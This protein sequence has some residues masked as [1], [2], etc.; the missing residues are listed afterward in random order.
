MNTIS[1][2]TW[3]VIALVA[4]AG[5]AAVG[6]WMVIERRRTQ[7]LRAQFGPEYER[8]LQRTRDRRRVEGK[9][10]NRMK[11]VEHLHIRA[12]TPRDR[13]HFLGSWQMI[14]AQFVDNPGTAV[15]EADRLV[16][17]VMSARGYPVSD[18]DFEQRAADISVD[19]PAVV[20][21][22]RMAHAIAILHSRGKASTEELRQAT[23][24]YRTVFEELINEP[25]EMPVRVAS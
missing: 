25:A 20:Q 4:I 8:E 11:R 3:I 17:D 13:A 23:I 6:A 7:R 15:A 10:D 9:L 24:Q 18:P 5:L 12:L 19:H 16:S 14:Q 22:Y 21:N 1:T 2:T